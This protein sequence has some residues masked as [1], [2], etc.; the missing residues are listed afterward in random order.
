MVGFYEKIDPFH[1]YMSDEYIKAY[2]ENHLILFDK[3]FENRIC[4][5]YKKNPDIEK[6]YGI[7][8][9]R[10]DYYLDNNSKVRKTR[11]CTFFK[12]QMA[13]MSKREQ[14]FL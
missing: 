1:L 14:D 4:E 11:N 6:R 12:K 10:I 3:A 8:A 7:I 9:N 5:Q 2:Q 13:H